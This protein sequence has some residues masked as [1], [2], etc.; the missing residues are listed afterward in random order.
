MKNMYP[1]ICRMTHK[2]F[3]ISS[4]RFMTENWCKVMYVYDKNN[5]C[6]GLV[7]KVNYMTM[8]EYR[9]KRIDDIFL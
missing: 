8:A 1:I 9:D 5:V 2:M 4:N 3:Y 7:D 6:L